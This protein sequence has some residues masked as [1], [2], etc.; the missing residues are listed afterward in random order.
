[1][2]CVQAGADRFR[3]LAVLGEGHD[4]AFLRAKVLQGD[5][6][7]EAQGE[8]QG[9]GEE[10]DAQLDVRQPYIPGIADGLHQADAACDKAFPVFK[11]FGGGVQDIA[12]R[13]G[14]CG[15]MQVDEGRVD[16]VEK[17][18]ADI[19]EACATRAAQKFAPRAGQDIAADGAHVQ[20]H[21]A[22]RLAGIEQVD[23]AVFAGDAAHLDRRVHEAAVGG[24]MGEGDQARARRNHGIKRRDVDLTRGIGGHKINVQAAPSG[25]LQQ[26]QIV[27]NIVG[28]VG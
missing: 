24:D 2:G 27:G 17:A 8:P 20:G 19:K 14:P 23:Q 9:G 6:G 26:G 18:L 10:G 1:M 28:G 22:D 21:L 4:S 12:I 25:L 15:R 3:L 7:D 13:A 11:P 16:L 5:A